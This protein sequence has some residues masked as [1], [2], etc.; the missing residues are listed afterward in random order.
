M[1]HR[2]EEKSA[3]IGRWRVRKFTHSHKTRWVGMTERGNRLGV[4]MSPL[5]ELWARERQLRPG[6]S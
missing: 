4:R 6:Q 5:R 3:P 1:W 2:F